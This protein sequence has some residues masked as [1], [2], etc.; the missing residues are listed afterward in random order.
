M[1]KSV[2]RT[3]R[4]TCNHCGGRVV[5]EREHW[6]DDPVLKCHACSRPYGPPREHEEPA[7]DFPRTTLVNGLKHGTAMS[8]K[9]GCRCEPCVKA[10][11][12]ALKRQAD[13][14]REARE[15]VTA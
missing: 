2:G 1:V 8:W 9:E 15:K 14:R 11:K 13:R 12:R 3:M 10:Y 6:E 7:K 5:L 4:V